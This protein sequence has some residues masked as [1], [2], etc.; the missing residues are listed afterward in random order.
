[1]VFLIYNNN[2]LDFNSD[3]ELVVNLNNLLSKS[4][5]SMW[6]IE[7][8]S[9]LILKNSNNER[10]VLDLNSINYKQYLEY[11]LIPLSSSK[12]KKIDIYNPSDI[13]NIFINKD[14]LLVDPYLLL[15]N[16][17]GLSNVAIYQAFIWYLNKSIKKTDTIVQTDLSN[18]ITDFINIDTYNNNVLKKSFQTLLLY[19][20]NSITA[21]PFNI[22]YTPTGI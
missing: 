15:T 14:I 10:I 8:K 7:S 11:F 17:F 1:M 3:I 21:S 16:Y 9:N 4:E 2:Q 6:E 22:I 5:N 18:I 13:Y 19:Y 20:I 12:F